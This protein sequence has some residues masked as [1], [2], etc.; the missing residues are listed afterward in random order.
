MTARAPI[1][2]EEH[3]K[4]ILA[5]MNGHGRTVADVI[6]EVTGN[7]PSEDTVEVVTNC[8]RL[9]QENGETVDIAQIIASLN[10]LADQWA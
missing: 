3:I 10:E 9:A 7:A 4:A 5:I 6:E 1:D 8:L 2:N